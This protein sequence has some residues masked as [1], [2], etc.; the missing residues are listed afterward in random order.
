MNRR[1]SGFFFRAAIQSVLLFGVDTWVVNPH[2]VRVLGGLQDQ[3]ARQ[4]TG[5]IPRQRLDRKW[6][7]TLAEAA[8]E[9]AG[10]E[11][12]ETYIRQSQNT[13]AL[14]MAT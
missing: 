1:V 4:L 13:V 10:F 11:L 8:R 9:K 2:M 14:Y 3:V 7:Y 12:M 6:E 5:R